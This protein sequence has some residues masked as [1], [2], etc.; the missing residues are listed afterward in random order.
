[1][2][3]RL[4]V[5]G[6]L[7]LLGGLVVFAVSTHFLHAYQVK[8][9]AGSLLRQA[10]RA[11]EQKNYPQAIDYLRRYLGVR[12][13]D[14]EALARYG[15]LLAHD[16]VATSPR[17]TRFAMSILEN[18]LSRDPAR[19]GE[20]QLLVRL[21][22]RLNAPLE[23]QYHIEYLLGLKD[24]EAIKGLLAEEPPG[25]WDPKKAGKRITEVL[26]N[27]P[28]KR[29][30]V[31]KL[32]LCQEARRKFPEARKFYEVALDVVPKDVANYVGLARV[33]REH[34]DDVRR[35]GKP[36]KPGKPAEPAE[37]AETRA[38]LEKKADK[39]LDDAVRNNPRSARAYVARAQYL[40][41]YPLPAGRAATLEAVERDLRKADELASDDADVL[42]ALAGLSLE[43]DRAA[44]ARAFLDRGLG[45]HPDDWRMYQA[46]A[47]LERRLNRPKEAVAALRTGLEKLPGQF[48]LLWELADLLVA[49]GSEEAPAAI[50]R[51]KDRGVA[52]AER[53]VLSARL[54]IRGRKWAD[55]VGLLVGAYAQLSGRDEQARSAFL[56]ALA[57]QCNVLLTRC[58]EALGDSF[59]A[60]AVYERIL[61]GNPRSLEARLG[62]A[63]AQL[64]LGQAKEAEI[65][66][67]QAAAL[68]GGAGALVEVARL[69]LIRNLRQEAPDWE[70]VNDAL[71]RAER[72]QPRPP[73][74]AL[75]RAEALGR[76]AEKEADPLLKKARKKQARDV[77]LLNVLGG[78][79]VCTGLLRAEMLPLAALP[80]PRSLAPLWVGLS[81]A[82]EQDGR[83]R[84]ALR[85]LEE[86]GRRFGDLVELRQARIRFWAR[87][88]KGEKDEAARALAAL[89]ERLGA[90]S[91]E[92]RRQLRVTLALA[93]ARLGQPDRAAG[94]W[95]EMAKD[96]PDDWSVRLVL[97]NQA[98]EKNDETGMDAHL[99]QLRR[100]EK[101]DGVLWRDATV[102]RLLLQA[103]REKGLA[104]RQAPLR[105]AR[106]I[107]KEIGDRWPGWVGVTQ[108]EAQIEDL[109]GSPD[110]ALPKYLEAI[111]K[112]AATVQGVWRA[113]ELLNAR[114]R[115]REA[116]AL[117][118]KLPRGGQFAPEL[119]QAAAVASLLANDDAEA[120]VRAERAAERATGDYRPHL[121][122]GQILWKGGQNDRALAC[123]RKA[124]ELNDAAPECWLTLIGFLAATDRKD[125]A[126]TE[127]ARAEKK[128]T[129]GP[130]RMALARCYEILGDNVKAAK[131]YTS[132]ESLSSTDFAVRRAVVSHYM[133]TGNQ[134]QARKR[135]R[136]LIAA[137]VDDPATAAWA[138]GMLAVLEALGGDRDRMI[139][140]M[141]E[142]EQGA[143]GDA[144]GL[145]TRAVLLASQ[146]NRAD[147]LKA[148][149]YLQQLV[150][151]ARDQPTD[152]LLMAQLYEANNDWPG[153]RRQL[154]AVLRMPGGRTA[155]NL[156]AYVSAMLRHDGLDEAEGALDELKKLQPAKG[157]GALALVLLQAQ[158]M[159]RRGKEKEAVALLRD[160]AKQ[161]DQGFGELGLILERLKE[162]RAAE[163]MYKLH[164]QKSPN[165]T[166][167]LA[168][169]AFLGR[170]KRF[171]E[172][173]DVCERAW[174]KAPAGVVVSTCLSLLEQ[175]REDRA[176]QARVERQFL[177]ALQKD[178][179]SVLLRHALANLH[180]LQARYADAEDVYAKLIR[181]SPGEVGARN[182]LA[183]LLACQKKRLKD[184]LGLIRQAVSRAG[185]RPT[186]QDTLAFVLLQDGQAKEAAGILE[187]LVK[188][189]PQQATYQF[190]LAQAFRAEGRRDDAR[191]VWRKAHAAAVGLKQSTLHPLERP[192]YDQLKREF[193]EP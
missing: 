78:M 101:D 52:Q 132:A 48:E 93:Y 25:N 141:K 51:L 28:T 27:D 112:G 129:G 69:V 57:G 184:A 113:M 45:K 47:G 150:N 21:A 37:P 131:V 44:Q 83:P 91:A 79:P 135:L 12:P 145:R 102:R 143:A 81:A 142:W 65:Q 175:A 32:G 46:V 67:T 104:G 186:L 105:Q 100:I 68:P 137:R 121:L 35:P 140:E 20:R 157:T 95:Q 124:R 166:A 168:Y 160:Y 77:L 60:H 24:A 80:P 125:Q 162:Y 156:I 190:H 138:R 139:A 180:V 8:R 38:M 193:G 106:E 116:S 153:A 72:L 15:R 14:T 34:G 170:Q 108:F 84:E 36:A 71:E 10:E 123:L 134:E 70:Q 172:A 6:L 73:A 115:F 87:Q 120:L 75:L 173:L 99:G 167:L 182:N 29:E 9:Q 22:L 163:D 43:Q 39:L 149:E 88:K 109:G 147:R 183:W 50:D 92:E 5:K 110:K 136:D 16:K 114:Q 62:L 85:L 192:A 42:L 177:S 26:E 89:G 181:E 151:E 103:S 144:N 118:E 152:R 58:Y 82:E 66:F 148:L 174:A 3:R 179:R 98:L 126:Q 122:L 1:M 54:L 187:A 41:F 94:L 146:G 86:C 23:V 111:R 61:A 30:L 63:R 18:V 59:R 191:T 159:Y 127:L 55:A 164:E 17:A 188:E 76:Q 165:K 97:F 56:T 119:E 90:F 74:V 154:Q 7:V 128:L 130:G 64:A 133:R 169:A 107:T 178:P 117:R 13:T 2:K 176:V 11:E 189:A 155:A 96:D 31:G 49:L 185:P 40:R 171:A 158:V 4:N 19:D 161:H 53:D 33:L